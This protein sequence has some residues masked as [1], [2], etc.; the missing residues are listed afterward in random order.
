MVLIMQRY[1]IFEKL[2]DGIEKCRRGVF[3][4]DILQE[5]FDVPHDVPDAF[6]LRKGL[7]SVPVG[8]PE[9]AD[10]GTAVRLS[11]MV[12]DDLG[13]T[14]FINVEKSDSRIGKNPEPVVFP[15]GFV[16]MN[17]RSFGERSFQR[18]INGLCLLRKLVIKPDNR[19]GGNAEFAEGLN[20]LAGVVVGN[21][22]FIAEK[23][24]F[25]PCFGADERARY[26]AISPAVNKFL[27]GSAPVIIMDKTRCRN[28]AVFKVFLNVFGAVGANGNI[29][30]A[31]ARASVNM[32]VNV[33]VY[34][35]GL[36]S[37]PPRMADRRAALLRTFRWL[38]LFR[39]FERRLE[40]LGKFSFKLA[41]VLF[42]FFD[43]IGEFLD[44]GEKFLH[45]LRGKVHGKFEFVDPLAEIVPV[46]KNPLWRLAIEEDTKIFERAKRTLRIIDPVLRKIKTPNPHLRNL[47]IWAG[48]WKKLHVPENCEERLRQSELPCAFIGVDILLY[49]K[50]NMLSI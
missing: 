35:V 13:T 28:S 50:R 26:F 34:F 24:S 7:D 38:F 40:R 1:G 29:F 19:A 14:A 41:V 49:N 4:R 20:G 22:D 18:L 21:L 45:L 9:I 36:F 42:E 39:L 27:A 15:T 47:S 48:T 10:D 3:R 43:F 46:S 8:V 32:N 33:F 16:G 37:E 44:F 2:F 30:V 6:L 12:D 25:G 17:K 31:A 11:E 5:V 23:T